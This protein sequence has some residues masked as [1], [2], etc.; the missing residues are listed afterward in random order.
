MCSQISAKPLNS[1]V[2]TSV[3]MVLD[4]H[5]P[6]FGGKLQNLRK[7]ISNAHHNLNEVLLLFLISSFSSS[8][9]C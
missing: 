2:T 3:I 8:F 5:S 1:S 6:I 9:P 4:W 7:S